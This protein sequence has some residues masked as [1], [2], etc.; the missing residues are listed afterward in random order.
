VTLRVIRLL[1]NHERVFKHLHESSKSLTRFLS[2]DIT[3]FTVSRKHGTFRPTLLSLVASNADTSIN[4]LTSTVFHSYY[5]SIDSSSESHA[6][7]IPS[8]VS[9]LTALKG[10][11]PATAS[12]ILSTVDP[13]RVPFFGDELFRWA[14]WD[15]PAPSSKGPAGTTKGWK[16]KIGYN[17]K[18]YVQLVDVVEQVRTRLGVGVDE[19]ERVAFVLG[20]EGLDLDSDEAVEDEEEDEVEAAEKKGSS[21]RKVRTSSS[22]AAVS[23]VDDTIKRRRT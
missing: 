5:S 8:F 10:V 17:A 13:E 21:K 11:G 14:M 18:E 15:T 20:K 1:S 7:D 12:L 6:S 22:G 9:R 23:E 16:R 4:S 2:Q 3:N 19:I